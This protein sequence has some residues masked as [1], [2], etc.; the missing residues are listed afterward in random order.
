MDINPNPLEKHSELIT[1]LMKGHMSSFSVNTYLTSTIGY[2][3]ILRTE[4]AGPINEQQREFLDI[5][6]NNTNR[7]SEHLNIFI[8]ASRLMFNPAKIYETD[9]DLIDIIKGLIKRA[10]EATDFQIETDL[11]TSLPSIKGDGNLISHS[12]HYIERI[13]EQVHPTHKGWIKILVSADKD[14]VKVVFSTNK[15]EAIYPAN[16]N[17]E[18]F[19]VQTVAE[20]HSGKFEILKSDDNIYNFIFTLPILK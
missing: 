14:S 18:L 16:E 12:I 15:D 4:A 3:N 13:I 20:L 11:S 6:T 1:H 10:E 17:P 9:F 7:L 2:S 8:T 19:I 5:I